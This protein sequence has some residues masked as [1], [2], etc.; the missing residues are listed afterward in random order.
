MLSNG[1]GCR[2]FSNW[3]GCCQFESS[4]FPNRIRWCQKGI[5]NFQIGLG[6]KLDRVFSKSDQVVSKGIEYFQIRLGVA[7][8]DRM[9]ANGMSISKSD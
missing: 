9:F 5:E 3:V 1:K 6:V 2:V 7:T 4:I 8:L